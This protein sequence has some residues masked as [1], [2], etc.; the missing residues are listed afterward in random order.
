[1]FL[2]WCVGVAFV[3]YFCLLIGSVVSTFFFVA[4]V[5]VRIK[6]RG[7][8][9]NPGQSYFCI[10][11]IYYVTLAE[12]ES[13]LTAILSLP[14]YKVYAK[15]VPPIC[16]TRHYNW[17]RT[18]DLMMCSPRDLGLALTWFAVLNVMDQPEQRN[19]RTASSSVHGQE[20]HQSLIPH[21]FQTRLRKGC[22]KKLHFLRLLVTWNANII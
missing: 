13:Q 14:I 8:F 9:A 1:M 16:E 10:T 11:I 15:L 22:E 6:L 18:S 17:H 4:I 2:F 21:I 3:C 7:Q 12:N 19:A 5:I 20:D